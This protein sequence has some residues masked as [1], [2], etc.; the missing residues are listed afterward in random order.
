[1]TRLVDQPDRTA[2]PGAATRHAG[3]HHGE[4]RDRNPR[5]TFFPSTEILA[6]RVP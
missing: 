1:M 3:R 5:L 6:L 4:G 2:I